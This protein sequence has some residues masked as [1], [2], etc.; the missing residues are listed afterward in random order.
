MGH[1]DRVQESIVDTQTITKRYTKFSKA[2][3]CRF[4]RDKMEPDYKNADFLSKLCSTQGKILPRK[5]T[6]N[7]A[8]HQRACSLEIKR[9]RYIVMM[10]YIATGLI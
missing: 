2:A 1:Q 7:C 10:P 4:C 9:A 5:R 6:G 3:R 8:R